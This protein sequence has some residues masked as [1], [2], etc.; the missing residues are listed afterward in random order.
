VMRYTLRTSAMDRILVSDSVLN[1]TSPKLQTVPIWHDTWVPLL[2]CTRRVV[3]LGLI[4]SV[5]PLKSGIVVFLI[6][7]FLFPILPTL[8]QLLP[9]RPLP[10]PPLPGVLA[11]LYGSVEL[12][13]GALI[14][15]SSLIVN[16]DVLLCSCDLGF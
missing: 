8:P 15:S 9:L 2:V 7:L 16:D 4:P 11:A 6:L 5:F 3:E 12:P 1:H 13:G 10:L 14:A